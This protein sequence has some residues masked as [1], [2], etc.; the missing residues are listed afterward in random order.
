MLTS[1]TAYQ[2]RELLKAI[3]TKQLGEDRV[4]RSDWAGEISSEA[5]DREEDQ[6]HE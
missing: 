5:L 1:I 2:Y 6:K 3:I 4:G